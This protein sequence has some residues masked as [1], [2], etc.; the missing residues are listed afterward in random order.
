[1]DTHVQHG[2]KTETNVYVYANYMH[3]YMHIDADF[4]ALLISAK[5]VFPRS[6]S[7]EMLYEFDR[8]QN[9]DIDGG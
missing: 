8:G 5:T 2:A 1:M 4:Y 9:R 3:S 7:A 6:L